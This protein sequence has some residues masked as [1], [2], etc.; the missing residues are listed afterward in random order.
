MPNNETNNDEN[1]AQ[2][3]PKRATATAGSARLVVR[4]KRRAEPD[5]RRLARALIDLAMEEIDA[6]RRAEERSSGEGAA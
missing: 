1:A 5:L 2:E 3:Q 4:V 6:E